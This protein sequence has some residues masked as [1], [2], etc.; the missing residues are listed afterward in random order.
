MQVVRL[1]LLFGAMLAPC[2]L[3]AQEVPQSDR[4]TRRVPLGATVSVRLLDGSVLYGVLDRHDA[5][6]VVVTGS[7]GRMAF[8]TPV[9][10]Q[11]RAAGEAHTRTD[12]AT[13]YWYPNPNTT[14]L[15]FAPTGRTLARGEGYF[16][17]H[18]VVL[19]SV[20]VGVT[21]RMTMGVGS[22]L[23]PNSDF[24]FVT[25]KIGIVRSKSVNVAVGALFGGV[26]G[27]TGGI[28]FVSSTFGSEDKNVTIAMGNA[29]SGDKL[30]NSQVYMLGGER[31]VSRRLS[32]VT[33]NYLIPGLTKPLISYGVRIL[34][35]K[36]SVDLAFINYTGEMVFP[37]IPY[38]D[39]V[40]RF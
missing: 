28:G 34:G 36:I 39:F 9:V 1:A 18:Y 33:E 14:R 40:V 29:F 5:D 32:L 17:D 30:A 24:W 4:T 2:L 25:P 3:S 37:G 7:S 22:F 35:E 6:S 27:E 38:V 26:D 12:G 19:G 15:F 21:D 8:P 31:R 23:I 16:A 10:R 11:L 13:E 20:A